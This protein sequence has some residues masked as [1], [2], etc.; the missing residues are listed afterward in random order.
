LTT[1]EEFLKLEDELASLRSENRPDARLVGALNRLALKLVNVDPERAMEYSIEALGLSEEL[2]LP[3]E[4]AN[5][6]KIRQ[7]LHPSTAVSGTST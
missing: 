3:P 7:V 6:R 1:E 2:E 5:C 4:T